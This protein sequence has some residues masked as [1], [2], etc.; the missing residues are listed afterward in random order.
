M[1]NLASQ[2]NPW[3]V[4]SLTHRCVPT[5]PSDGEGSLSAPGSHPRTRSTAPVS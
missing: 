5:A 1:E 2:A 4:L 3:A